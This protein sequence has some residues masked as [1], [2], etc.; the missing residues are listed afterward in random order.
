MLAML[1]AAIEV[2][3]VKYEVRNRLVLQALGEASKLGLPCGI[4]SDERDPDWPVMFIEL[5]GVGQVSWHIP[6]HTRKWDGHTTAEKYRR[7]RDYIA[8]EGL[9]SV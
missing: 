5:P 3:D 4:G 8:A 1:L 7:V 2:N 6:A 9:I